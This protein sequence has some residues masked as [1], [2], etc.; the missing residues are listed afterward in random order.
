MLEVIT[1]HWISTPLPKPVAEP[2]WMARIEALA[3][4]SPHA[5]LAVIGQVLRLP[6]RS[7]P[8]AALFK[9]SFFSG[10]VFRITFATGAVS[11]KFSYTT[12]AAALTAFLV[13]ALGGHWL[14][15]AAGAFLVA[16][17]LLMLAPRPRP[18]R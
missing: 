8:S 2:L 1:K 17:G 14:L 7:T 11:R 9:G 18:S 15:D 3:S 6:A 10:H 13:V 16:G 4:P 5:A 12:I